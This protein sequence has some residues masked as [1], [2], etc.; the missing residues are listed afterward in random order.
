MP[1]LY[2]SAV[3]VL[4]PCIL[5]SLPGEM[6]CLLP[7]RK[8]IP[9]CHQ[10][11]SESNKEFVKRSDIVI[12]TKTGLVLLWRTQNV[13]CKHMYFLA[14]RLLVVFL[15][16][17]HDSP[18]HDSLTHTQTHTLTRPLYSLVCVT[19]HSFH[20]L[21]SV[22]WS[23]WARVEAA[24][25]SSSREQECGDMLQNAKKAK[26]KNTCMNTYGIFMRIKQMDPKCSKMLLFLKLQLLLENKIFLD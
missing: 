21:S 15:P 5:A 26:Q 24:A 25:S 10:C 7:R 1:P 14:H 23:R 12:V 22:V 17:A 19:F 13:H 3:H 4:C 11:R 9:F 6:T 2:I 16:C 8:Q 18:T 20:W